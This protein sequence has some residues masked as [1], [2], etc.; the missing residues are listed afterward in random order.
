MQSF[1][2]SSVLH[3]LVRNFRSLEQIADASQLGYTTQKLQLD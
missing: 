1:A 3:N 2:A